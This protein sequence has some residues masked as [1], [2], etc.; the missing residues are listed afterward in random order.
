MEPLPTLPGS[1]ELEEQLATTNAAE[2][3]RTYQRIE[4]A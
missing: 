3:D 4:I 2:R 1:L